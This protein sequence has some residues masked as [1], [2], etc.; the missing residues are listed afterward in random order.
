MVHSRDERYFIPSENSAV[1]TRGRWCLK[2]TSCERSGALKTDSVGMLANR[3]TFNN[4]PMKEKNSA[5]LKQL[6]CVAV[7]TLKHR[8]RL[9][10]SLIHASNIRNTNLYLQLVNGKPF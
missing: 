10:N 1:C 9:K 8:H 7:L 3:S 4:S 2:A 6:H 5:R